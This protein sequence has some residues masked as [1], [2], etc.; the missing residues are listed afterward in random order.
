MSIAL[1]GLLIATLFAAVHV[2]GG[3]LRF[4]DKL[5][6]SRWLSFAGGIS[7]AYVFVQL[8]PEL[9]EHQEIV[10]E[11]VHGTLFQRVEAHVWLIALTGLSLFYC[12]EQFIRSHDVQRDLERSPRFFWLHVCFFFIYNLLIGYLLIQSEERGALS[13]V[14]YAIALTLHL[15]VVDQGLRAQHGSLYHDRGRWLLAAAPVAGALLALATEVTEL[16]IA[17]LIAFVGGSV[18][19]NVMKEELPEDRQSRFGA[20]LLGAGGYSAL[21]LLAG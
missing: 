3:R 13:T 16:A 18:I 21:L 4:L 19:L 1:P 5:P 11:G 17:A 14:F 2:F 8:L 10:Q 20:F 15:L 9:A 6:R 12:L 7:V